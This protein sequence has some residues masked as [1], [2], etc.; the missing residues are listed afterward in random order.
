MRLS[1]SHCLEVNLRRRRKSGGYITR[2]SRVRGPSMQP[3]IDLGDHLRTHGWSGGT[4]IGVYLGAWPALL[5][6]SQAL[7]EV[8]RC[9]KC[10]SIWV[11]GWHLIL[12]QVSGPEIVDKSLFQ[13]LT[14]L[15]HSNNAASLNYTDYLL[16]QTPLGCRKIFT[17][18]FLRRLLIDRLHF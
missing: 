2:Q 12:Y 9:L 14:I 11:P 4:N 10:D 6:A 17:T 15:P 13:F 3:R 7:I 16:W 18:P 1:K 5:G 8:V